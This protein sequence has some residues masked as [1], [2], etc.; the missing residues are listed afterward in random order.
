MTPLGELL[1]KYVIFLV[2]GKQ[3]CLGRIRLLKNARALKL[4]SRRA[5]CRINIKG[6]GGDSAKLQY[7]I[8]QLK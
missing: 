6:P 5:C 1:G 8:C 7:I 2:Y 3:N 4:Y